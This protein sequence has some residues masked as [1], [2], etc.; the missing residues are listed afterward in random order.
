VTAE[1]LHEKVDYSPYQD[2]ALKGFPVMTLLKGKKLIET[3]KLL[4]EEPSGEY[5]KCGLP[6]IP[7]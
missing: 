6:G 3:G 7:S 1:N 2:F 4:A 5:L